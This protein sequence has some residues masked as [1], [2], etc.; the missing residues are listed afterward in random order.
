MTKRILALVALVSLA[1]GAFAEVRWGQVEIAFFRIRGADGQMIDLPTKGIVLPV[2]MERITVTP[3]FPLPHT[4]SQGETN[5]F[6][7][8]NEVY[9]N[10][11]GEGTYF[12]DP[13]GPSSCDDLTILPSGNGQ[14]WYDLTVGVY[15][16]NGNPNR[17][18]MLR[19]LGW[20]NYVSGLGP[21]VSAL[22]GLVF[23]V[24]WSFQPGQFP[25]APDASTA[26][27]FTIPI[28]NY[29]AALQLDNNMMKAPQGLI[30][31]AQEWRE[32]NAQGEGAF[33]IND[34][35]PVFC[36]NGDPTIGSSTDNYINDWDPQPD[37]IFDE[38]ENDYF[39]GPPSEANFLVDLTTQASGVNETVYPDSVT[40]FRGSYQGGNN[41][42]FKFIDQNYYRANKGFVANPTENPVQIILE[43]TVST[44]NLTGLSID[45]VS[46]FSNNSFD[47]IIDAW[48][49]TTSQWIQ[50]DRRHVGLSDAHITVGV[51]GVAAQFVDAAH[52]NVMKMRIS[53]K[54]TN[55]IPNPVYG[56]KI[57]LG[58]WIASHP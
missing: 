16:V 10:D 54:Q 19:Q 4:Y 14:N 13:N 31:F 25:P 58:T 7:Q 26:W 20:N 32:W 44:A 53:Y 37:G 36:G 52:F 17:K 39:G 35:A 30:Y 43:G 47:Q 27:K 55:F 49:Y 40:L 22:Q 12:F 48:N 6:P 50:V 41:A 23:D 15:T 9:K 29:W 46:S 11:K 33:I 8:V 18:V 3:K 1:S 51:P 38:T 5:I 42:S 45:V 57:D 24:G 28:H 56:C 21:G 2:K 34:F